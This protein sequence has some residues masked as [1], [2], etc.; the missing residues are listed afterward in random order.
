MAKILK[1]FLE[2]PPS[3]AL[4]KPEIFSRFYSEVLFCT[5]IK[6]LHKN[7]GFRGVNIN[8]NTK[9]KT[10]ITFSFSIP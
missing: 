3:F 1:F 5:Q 9:V 8:I 2:S 7:W 6:K 10:R 4:Y